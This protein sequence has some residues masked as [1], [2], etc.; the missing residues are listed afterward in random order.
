MRGLPLGKGLKNDQMI[1]EKE[2]PAL[3]GERA[4]YL[5][6]EFN[7]TTV[8]FVL[9]YEGEVDPQVLGQAV[10]AVIDSVDV[11]HGS[12]VLEKGKTFWRIYEDVEEAAYFRHIRVERDAREAGY[13]Q[14]LLGVNAE[15]PVKL[16]CTLV[17]DGAVSSVVLC[18]SHM[19][20]DGGDAKYLLGKIVE[21]Y[22][23][24]AQTG[25]VSG[26]EVK[27]GSRAPEQL[28]AS[29]SRKERMALWSNPMPGTKNEFPFSDP[30]PGKPRMLRRVI[31]R[32][33]MG[34]AREKARKNGM[35]ANDLILAGCYQAF[36]AAPG[37]DE[38]SPIGVMAMMDLRRH[39][40]GGDSEGLTNMAGSLKTVMPGGVTGT[41]E[42]TLAEV[43]RQTRADKEDPM[44]GM[45]GVPLMHWA[46]RKS[47]M[48]LLLKAAPAIYGNMSVGVTNLG[49]LRGADMALGGLMPVDGMMGGPLKKKPGV[50]VSVLSI[51][52][53]CAL[54]ILGE[55][56]D[57]DVEGL[58]QFLDTLVGVIRDYGEKETV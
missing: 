22:N 32:E 25:S 40:P 31:S 20:A 12:F 14:A 50:Q 13:E 10:R 26:L 21:A 29:L 39:C 17:Q 19:V 8:R 9:N 4:Q 1:L 18:V 6:R 7:D 38:T 48:G 45:E 11:L 56:T 43:A 52:G 28:Y 46:V 2:I 49:N 5:V 23:R 30:E 58:E 27:N 42:Q 36:A 35:T 3:T 44:S 41:F 33:V 24:I 55:Y 57:G 51:D 47:P 53:E 16:R 37:V 54:S 15:E 34:A